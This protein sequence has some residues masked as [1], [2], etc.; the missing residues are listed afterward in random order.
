M[1]SLYAS[2]NLLTLCVICY[3]I[4]SEKVGMKTMRPDNP[5]HSKEYH[6]WKKAVKCVYLFNRS[7]ATEYGQPGYTVVVCI[8]TS[9]YTN[10]VT[11]Y[12]IMSERGGT[13]I[14][15]RQIQ[16]HSKTCVD[17]TGMFGGLFVFVSTL[18]RSI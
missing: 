15:A 5:V 2:I 9:P 18:G 1:I 4:T 12:R 11:Y 7:Q 3:R 13:K 17:G 10:R 14:A 16:F 8:H 6:P